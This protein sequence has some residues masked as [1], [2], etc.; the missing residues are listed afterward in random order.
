MLPG[1]GPG[2]PFRRGV[3]ADAAPAGVEAASEALSDGGTGGS[4]T[5][6]DAG[7][8]SFSLTGEEVVVLLLFVLALTGVEGLGNRLKRSGDSFRTTM[9]LE[10]AVRPA[11]PLVVVEVAAIVYFAVVY[12]GV[13]VW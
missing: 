8:P 3:S 6:E 4:A 12:S 7:E 9:A 13:E 10:L 11:R 5:E 1:L 2:N